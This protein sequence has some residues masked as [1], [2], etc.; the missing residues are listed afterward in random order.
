MVGGPVSGHM[1]GL[2]VLNGRRGHIITEHIG[3]IVMITAHD[4]QLGIF[5][6]MR[7][8]LSRTWAL[9]RMP[10]SWKGSL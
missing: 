6:G 10:T 1:N 2:P 3:Q 8:R 4:G 9:C 7:S 5:K